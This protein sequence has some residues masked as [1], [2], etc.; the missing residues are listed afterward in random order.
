M[1]AENKTQGIP[2]AH[3]CS[4]GTKGDQET[5]PQKEFPGTT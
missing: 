3:L 5:G 2:G 1:V 4:L